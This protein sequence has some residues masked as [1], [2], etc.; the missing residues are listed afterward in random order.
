MEI[1]G[2]PVAGEVDIALPGYESR[3]ISRAMNRQ[4]ARRASGG[5]TRSS[6]IYASTDTSLENT[7]RGEAVL[8]SQELAERQHQGGLPGKK[9]T[10]RISIRSMALLRQQRQ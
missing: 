2:T 4:K 9:S 5:L 8:L 6:H 10:R 7:H 3:D 1:G